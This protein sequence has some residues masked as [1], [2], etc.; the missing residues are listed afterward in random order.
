M[1]PRSACWAKCWAA[2]DSTRSSAARSVGGMPLR[3]T[4]SSVMLMPTLTSASAS[5]AARSLPAPTAA[6]RGTSKPIQQQLRQGQ[7]ILRGSP[8]WNLRQVTPTCPQ[9]ATRA[10]FR[11]DRADQR[12]YDHGPCDAEKSG[13][14]TVSIGYE[15]C[16]VGAL[17][18]QQRRGYEPEPGGEK[19]R[20]RDRHHVADGGMRAPAGLGSLVPRV[21]NIAGQ[22]RPTPWRESPTSRNITAELMTRVTRMA[23]RL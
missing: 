6:S 20:G 9:Q 5:E 16:C 15:I 14:A 2:P 19:L 13:H 4:C 12:G 22:V 11:P 17:Q 1:Q 8:H 23:A 3:S 21:V 18:A 7:T 10:P